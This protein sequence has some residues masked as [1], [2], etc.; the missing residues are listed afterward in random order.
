MEK[1]VYLT[2]NKG[3]D[4]RFSIRKDTDGAVIRTLEL[5]TERKYADTGNIYQ[6]NT[7]A[8]D[9]AVYEDFLKNCPQFKKAVENKEI[10][11]SLENAEFAKQNAM[12]K[13]AEEKKLLEKELAETKAR[14]TE[15]NTDKEKELE[16]ENASLKKQLEAL[17]KA[18]KTAKQT[19]KKEF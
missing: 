6:S 8:C 19:E 4:V 7:I 18:K 12:D 3:Y 5:P 13:L 17:A 1:T 10:L 2:N 9:N 16:K 14:L 15:T 11:M